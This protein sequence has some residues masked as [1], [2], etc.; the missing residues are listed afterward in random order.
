[1]DYEK[2]Y[3]QA[4]KVAEQIKR[5]VEN[6][7]CKMDADMLEVIFPELK[8]SKD[9]KIKRVIMSLVMHADCSE[10]DGLIPDT[11][12]IWLEEQKPA[13]WSEEDDARYYGV[14]ETEQYMLDVVSGRKSFDVGNE[15]IE[16]ECRKEL[17]WLK[18]L[19]W[20]KHL[21]RW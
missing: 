21:K 20:R 14:I 10:L 7:G 18:S 3:K 17:I 5:D 8:E 1:M 9:E 11:I 15:S 6:V 4:L 16:E 2:K 13:E 19:R 12:K